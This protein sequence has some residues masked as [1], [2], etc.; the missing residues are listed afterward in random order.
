MKPRVTNEGHVGNARQ[1]LAA[2]L[3][4]AS[5]LCAMGAAGLLVLPLVRD[6]APSPPEQE[7]PLPEAIPSAPPAAGAPAADDIQESHEAS[8]GALLSLNSRPEGATVWVNGLEQGET[9]LMVGLDCEAGSTV[10]VEFVLRGYE[11]TTHRT[12]CPRESM[13]TVKARLKRGGT[14]GSPSRR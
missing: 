9:P 7:A 2:V 8:S 4:L 6:A 12:E 11:R 1:K 5:A 3:K 10:V 14:E 13:L